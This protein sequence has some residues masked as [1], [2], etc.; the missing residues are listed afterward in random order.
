[1][2]FYLVILKESGINCIITTG[3]LKHSLIIFQNYVFT[4]LNQRMI[5]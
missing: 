5:N 2:E 1:M 4:F 3:I